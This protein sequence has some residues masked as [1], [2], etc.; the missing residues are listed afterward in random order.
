VYSF[1][2]LNTVL[3][4]FFRV[5]WGCPEM[6]WSEKLFSGFC[7]DVHDNVV[8]LSSFRWVP[9]SDSRFRNA[10][11]G[12]GEIKMRTGQ[13]NWTWSRASRWDEVGSFASREWAAP[14]EWKLAL[15]IY[16]LCRSV[17]VNW[18]SSADTVRFAIISI[19]CWSVE[20]PV[21]IND[22]PTLLI[23]IVIHEWLNSQRDENSHLIIHYL[24]KFVLDSTN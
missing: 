13:V 24:E 18:K 12:E 14:P 7:C 23:H 9:S 20:I 2:V 8:L 22:L 4:F 19:R 1:F 6:P 3:V 17:I 15:A 5:H 11:E 10:S 21:M 16:L